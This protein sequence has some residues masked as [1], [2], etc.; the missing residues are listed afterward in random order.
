[1][2]EARGKWIAMRWQALG[3]SRTP[4]RARCRIWIEKFFATNRTMATWARNW[5]REPLASCTHGRCP[6]YLQID[7]R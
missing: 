1:M 4:S 2:E 7:M 6:F 3:R 5:K